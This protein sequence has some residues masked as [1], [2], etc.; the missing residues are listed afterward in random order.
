[1]N[2]ALLTLPEV[3]RDRRP[4][5]LEMTGEYRMRTGGLPRRRFDNYRAHRDSDAY[6]DFER[7]KLTPIG[8]YA[9]L[10]INVID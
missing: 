2:R 1:M 7:P 4:E 6:R 8:V 10:W 9:G 3:S 5:L